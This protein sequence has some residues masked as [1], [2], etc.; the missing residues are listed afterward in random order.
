MIYKSEP[1]VL[2]VSSINTA[3]VPLLIVLK[4]SVNLLKEAGSSKKESLIV[5]EM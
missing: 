1:G 4:L 3:S 5:K 2:L